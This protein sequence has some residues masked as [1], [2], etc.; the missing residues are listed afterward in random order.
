VPAGDD[1][2]T[3][4]PGA[5]VIGGGELL[6]RDDR[7]MERGVHCAEYADATGVGEQAGRPHE[8][9]KGAAVEVGVLPPVG[10]PGDRQHEVDSYLVGEPGESKIVLPGRRPSLGGRGNRQARCR[11]GR[12]EPELKSHGTPP[13]PVGNLDPNEQSQ[14]RDPCRVNGFTIAPGQA[15]TTITS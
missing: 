13:S 11:V 15:S 4:P 10:P 6:G 12:E 2:Q 5:D 9:I 8:R 7:M 3:D 1:V 14:G